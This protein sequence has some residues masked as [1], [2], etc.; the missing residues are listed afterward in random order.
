MTMH[1]SYD[2]LQTRLR[3][4]LNSVD[5]VL[6]SPERG[7]VAEFIEVNELGIALETLIGYL[8]EG[9]HDV[10]PLVVEEAQRLASDMGLS[11]TLME[12]LRVRAREDPK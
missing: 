2:A 9:R 6:T 10:T 11:G 4:L 7:Q 3:A 1:T 5:R 12:E 8:V